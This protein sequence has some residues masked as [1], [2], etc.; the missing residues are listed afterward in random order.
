LKTEG[1]QKCIGAATLQCLKFRKLQQFPAKA[2]PSRRRGYGKPSNVQPSRPD[3]SEQT[4]QDLAIFV[5]EKECDRI[6]F[7]L[8]G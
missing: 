7:S 5:L 4:A 3:L 2:T 6:P 1:V 8:P